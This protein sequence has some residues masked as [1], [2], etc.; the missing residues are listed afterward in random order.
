MKLDNNAIKNAES[1]LNS[2]VST[3]IKNEIKKLKEE[4]PTQ[5]NDAFYKKLSFGTGGLR[6]IMGV[7]TNRMNSIVVGQS[8]QGFANYILQQCKDQKEIKVAI[9]F[10]SR[11]NSKEFAEIVA[12]VFAANGMK[13]Y[14]FKDIHPTP[15][16]SFAVRELDCC[17]GVMITASHN[18]KEYN[19]YKAYWNDGG[20]LVPP[21]DKD[22][23]EQV[24]KITDISQVKVQQGMEN[25]TLLDEKF[26]EIYYKAIEKESLG[27][28]HLDTFKNIRI[29]YTP[30]HGTGYKMVPKALELWG[31]KNVITEPKQTIPDGDFSTCLSPNPEERVALDLVLKLADD[32]QCDIVLATDPDADR[33]ALCVRNSKGKMVLLNGNQTATLLVYYTLLRN[34]ELN[35]LKGKE[36]IVKTIVTSELIK[37]LADDYGV[38]CYDVLTGFKW[39]AEKV[40]S[41]EGKEKYIGGGEE[42]YGYMPSDIVR[43]KDAVVTCCLLAEMA[44]WAKQQGQ[45]LYDVLLEIY[46]RYGYYQESLFSIVRK[47]KMG[48]EEI[49]KMMSDFR[50]NPPK[51]IL[52]QPLVMIK[53]YEK[54]ISK[55][56]LNKK[57]EKLDLP[58][59]NVLQWFLK[60]GSKISVRPSGTEPKIKFYFGVRSEYSIGDDF[61]Q[62]QE[63]SLAKIERIKQELNL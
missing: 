59:S 14:L 24:N 63:Q 36:F 37:V 2:S 47:G 4:D 15:L 23:I 45:T 44:S 7:G 26:D 58:K 39:I 46:Q 61:E 55:D 38:K 50:S 57:D 56:L 53:D 49:E 52:G 3:E 17:A 11:H 21:H 48:A 8:T 10:D 40:L 6:G 32:K 1:W 19:G 16:L 43:D 13:V 12:K 42:S 51:E 20:Q 9:S 54:Q 34:K 25:I 27:S 35:R 18:P 62:L 30:L 60:D 5:F 41:L 33:E 22:V 29:A 31:F 28:A